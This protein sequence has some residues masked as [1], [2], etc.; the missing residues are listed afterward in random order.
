MDGHKKAKIHS[1][2]KSNFEVD[3]EVY[4]PEL[5]DIYQLTKTDKKVSGVI[6]TMIEMWATKQYGEIN[7]TYQDGKI[8]IVSKT[9]K[10]RD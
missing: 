2:T 1:G 3:L 5:Y 8:N 10:V 6:K 9:T 4:F 7:I